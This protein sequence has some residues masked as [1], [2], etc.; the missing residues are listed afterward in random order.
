MKR[1]FVW[2]FILALAGIAITSSFL[3]EKSKM[4]KH[5][6]PGYYASQFGMENN[7]LNENE[8]SFYGD[9]KNA[10]VNVQAQKRGKNNFQTNKNEAVKKPDI[11]FFIADDMTSVDCEPYGNPDVKTPNLAKLAK[12]GMCFDNMNNATAM[13]GPT[14][15]S[16][17][18]GIYPVRNGSYPN[19]AQVYDNIVSVVQHFKSIGYRVALIGKQH[20]APM[21]NFP[22]EYLGGRN[23][24]NGEGIDI[25]LSDAEKWINKDKSK[26]YLLIVATNQPHGPWTRG[27]PNQ[28]DAEKLTV[29]PYMV[30]TKQTRESLVKYYA[31]I[32]YADSLVGYCMNMVDKRNKDNTMF[33]FASEHGTSLPFGKWTCYNMG[34]KAAFIVRWPKVI[35][36]STRTGILAQYIDVVPTLY[37]AAGGNPETLRG[38]KA[39]TMRL[40]GKSFYATL[41]GTNTEVRTYVYGV[42]TT[43]GI[44][45]GSENY[46]VRSV[47]NKDYKLIWNLNYSEPFYCS[48][49]REGNKLYEGWLEK[50]KSNPEQHAHAVLYRTRPEFEL[51]NIRKDKYELKNLAN[52]PSLQKIKAS[53]FA[54]LQKWMTQQGD[55]GIETEWKALTRFKGDTLH[56]KTSAD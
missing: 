42:H 5:F 40:D 16:L 53:L 17:Y 7:I 41:K 10:H 33:L 22:F 23:S 45:N 39:K 28:Y 49:S 35:K 29:A 48:A 2:M 46:P 8:S 18:T 54:E 13:C 6:S 34:L 9:I 4:V 38:D 25:T 21:A 47:Q 43:R 52:E 12:E 26:P 3:P 15:Q 55:K 50:S 24:D 51:Y 14:R 37:Q 19:H 32:T 44:K 11:L 36:P 56:W 31:E 27:N 30:D 1:N 20:Y